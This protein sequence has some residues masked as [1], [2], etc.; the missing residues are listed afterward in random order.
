MMTID[1]ANTW[2]RNALP[3]DA[4]QAGIALGLRAAMP[5]DKD[6]PFD[7][8][9]ALQRAEAAI[10]GARTPQPPRQQ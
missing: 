8:A 7:L 6:V 5:V 2:R 9:A 4:P 3:A 1:R 10:A